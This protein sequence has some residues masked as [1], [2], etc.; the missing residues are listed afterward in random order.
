[1]VEAKIPKSKKHFSKFIDNSSPNSIFLKPIDNDEVLSIILKL[2]TYK[3]CGPNSI[4]ST[5]LKVHCDSLCEP[6]KDILNMSLLQGIIPELLKDSE[7]CPIYKNNDKNKCENY[8]PISLLS[9]L[10]KLF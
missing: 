4:P 1:M 2:K 7:V 5:I 8:R 6:L 9:N 3:A 10:S